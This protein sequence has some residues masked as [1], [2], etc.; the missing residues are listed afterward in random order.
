MTVNQVAMTV[1]QVAM[2][3]N[4]VAMTL[5]QVVMTVNL[6]VMTVSQVAMTVNPAVMTVNQVAMTVNPA[7]RK[8]VNPAV[9]TVSRTT[10]VKR[11]HLRHQTEPQQP[12]HKLQVCTLLVVVIASYTVTHKTGSLS[13]KNQKRC[14]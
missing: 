13:N 14:H 11:R 3:V 10:A 1:S 2:T 12:R 9:T 7:V 6:E 8:V 4:R 5:S